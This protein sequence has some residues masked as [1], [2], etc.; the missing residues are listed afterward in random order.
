MK[1]Q[2]IF[3]LLFLK[4]VLIFGQKVKSSTETDSILTYRYHDRFEALLYVDTQKAHKYIDSLSLV[5]KT[6]RFAK[7][8]YYYHRDLGAINFVEHHLKASESHYLKAYQLAKK[9]NWNVEA[10]SSKIWLANLEYF[11]NDFSS[12]KSR[13][14]EVLAE[15]S[16]I[17]F[18]DGIA[19]AFY[20][21][22]D[23][24]D[25]KKVALKYLIK[26][27]SVYQRY[28]T[29]SPILANTY[30]FI[31]RIYLETFKNSAIA[32]D[33][34]LKALEV[35]NQTNYRSGINYVKNELTYLDSNSGDYD[36][37]HTYLNGLLN[38][39]L[40]NKDSIAIARNLTL[41]GKLEMHSNNLN[42]AEEHFKTA[43][44]YFMILD[45]HF[46]QDNI[47]LLLAQV[48]IKKKDP[49]KAQLFLDRIAH[50]ETVPRNSDFIEDNFKAQIEILVLNKDFQ[51]AL[52][53]QQ[54]LDSLKSYFF[55]QKND[56]AFLA[57]ERQFQTQ[58]KEQEIVLLTTQNELTQQQ[59][60]N[61]RNLFLSIIL[62]VV[63][64]AFT[65][66][67]LYRNR[68]KINRKLGELDAFK[69]KFYVNISH[70]FRTPLT[71]L[72]GPIEKQLG[73]PDLEPE[74]R[75][76]LNLMHRNIQRLLNLVNQLLDLSK[77]ETGRL[78]LHVSQGNLQELLYA[79]CSAFEYQ[80]SQKHIDFLVD[81]K[82]DEQAWFDKDLLEKVLINLLSNAFKYSPQYVD[83]IFKATTSKERLMIYIENEGHPL[84]KH[85]IDHLFDRFY[86][87]DESAEGVGIGLSYVKELV[88]LSHGS[89]SVE[90]ITHT[91]IA[92]EVTLP[93][94]KHQFKVEELQK[95][96]A[97]DNLIE[98]VN[99]DFDVAIEMEQVIDEDLPIMLLIEDHQDI[100]NFINSSFKH[101]YQIVETSNG[102]EGLEKAIEL[103]PDIIISDVM[104]P[105]MDGFEL[106]SKLK[107]DERTCHIPIVLLTG[108][109]E[110][111]DEFMG[112][113]SGADDYIIKP[114]KIKLLESRVKNLL[115]NRDKLRQRYSQEL[116]LKPKDIVITN[117]DA[118]FFEK[119]TTVLDEKL[120]ESSFSVEDFSKAVGMSRMQLHRKLKALTGLTTTEFVRN[121]RLK[122]ATTLIGQSDINISEIGYMVGFNDHS[123]FTKCFKQAYGCSPSEYLPSKKS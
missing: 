106:T 112:L 51:K 9:R 74:K 4:T 48:Q 34:F 109:A 68:Q 92:F 5:S 96:N 59:K 73:E 20:G 84:T 29:I 62:V 66:Y 42:L 49:L 93:I 27:D 95:H 50:I 82:T 70:E 114:F 18:V 32:K 24:Q 80:A 44:D 43:R 97:E 63:L 117:L 57:L 123:Y 58:K 115:E 111:M 13:Y 38:Q 119:L 1:L 104:M 91:T 36:K 14:Q 77:L 26:V 99:S 15:S 47:N 71:L 83:V 17:G 55:V 116:I 101:Q 65:F 102:K 122:L 87:A 86:Q 103:V 8:S 105:I 7:S 120:T 56:E 53:K 6:N 31:G 90:Q 19:N 41:M 25:D 89:I 10:I 121:Q 61:Q 23:L 108:K 69:S 40:K 54:E 98:L 35:S 85:Q 72:L 78:K 100:R 107:Q 118:I 110:E 22:A 3:F 33:Y 37:L 79:L 11:K 28:D 64:A 2:N 39:S 52:I 67:A 16:K 30:D 21:L 12:A 94:K 113:E 88:H 60:T 46:S 75:S 76:E 45:D 81:I